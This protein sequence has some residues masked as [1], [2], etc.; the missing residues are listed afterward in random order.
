LEEQIDFK[1]GHMNFTEAVTTAFQN[2]FN[3]QTRSRRSEYWYFSLFLFLVFIATGLADMLLF[4]TAAS[5]SGPLYVISMLATFIPS[6]AVSVRRLHDIERSG[7]YLLLCLIPI[8]G[9]II[10]IYWMCQPGTSGQNRF[11]EDPVEAGEVAA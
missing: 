6:L 1:G 11:G 7:W 4:N 10:L 9:L 8:V 2:Y 5:E 3:F